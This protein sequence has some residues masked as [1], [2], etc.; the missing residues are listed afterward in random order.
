MG[1]NTNCICIH[2][3]PPLPPPPHRRGGPGWGGVA[4]GRAPRG[5]SSSGML[6]APRACS[7]YVCTMVRSSSYHFSRCCM[8][9][10]SLPGSGLLPKAPPSLSH[11]VLDSPAV[12]AP[13][14]IPPQQRRSSQPHCASPPPPG[15]FERPGGG[16]LH[17]PTG[18]PGNHFGEGVSFG[19]KILSAPEKA[20]KKM[21][22]PPLT[23]DPQGLGS[24]PRR[25]CPG[26]P[27]PTP[28]GVQP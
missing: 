23:G 4:V 7:M 10:A 2:L 14:P 9:F 8:F 3:H 18:D 12:T 6:P 17:S 22:K 26:N 16:G 19:Q 13:P 5:V 1:T 25:G 11:G 15:F 20:T 27:P 21:G 24:T 28:H